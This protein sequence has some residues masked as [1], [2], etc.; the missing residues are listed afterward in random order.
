MARSER[1]G[2]PP[3]R[4]APAARRWYLLIH[5]IPPRPLYLR[6]EIRHRLDRGGAVPH[7]KSG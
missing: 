3:E 6:A 1:D 4:P 5:Q 7:K 2:D